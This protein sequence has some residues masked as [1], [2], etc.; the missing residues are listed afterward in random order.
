MPES[1]TFSHVFDRETI[2]NTTKLESD[3]YTGQ[4]MG[5]VGTGKESYVFYST[6]SQGRLV[7]VKIHRHDINAFK[8]IPAYLRLRGTKTSGFFRRIDDWTRYEFRFLS[9]AFNAGVNVPEPYRAYKNII[10][11]KFLGDEAGP[12][13]PAYRDNDFDVDVWYEKMIGFIILMGKDGFLHGDLSAYNVLN[14]SK[15]PYLIDFSQAL[16]LTNLTKEYLLRDIRNVNEWFR[17][18]GKQDIMPEDDVIRKI[19]EDL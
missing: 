2:K 15:E 19:D 16:K 8:K 13:K 12:A 3:G 6:D 10:V 5:P 7:A 9:R 4:L 17:K 18:L 1:K 11:M 14:V